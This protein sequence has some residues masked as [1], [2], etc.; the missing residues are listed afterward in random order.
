MLNLPSILGSYFAPWLTWLPSVHMECPGIE[1]RI[2][3]LRKE[4][5]TSPDFTS[6]FCCEMM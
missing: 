3:E 6:D 4:L 1:E 5:R 2:E